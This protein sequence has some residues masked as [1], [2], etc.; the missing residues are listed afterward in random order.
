VAVPGLSL[1]VRPDAAQLCQPGLM[2]APPFGGTDRPGDILQRSGRWLAEQLGWRWVK[3]RCDAEV[4]AGRQ[5][6]RL[7]LQPS[8]WNRAGVA[9]WASTRVTVL[10]ED[11]KAW[12]Q[13]HPASTVL[14]AS[15]YPV[16]PHVYNTLL[17]NVDLDLAEV[18]CSGLPQRFP[19]PRVTAGVH[20]CGLTWADA[21]RPG[22]EPGRDPTYIPRPGISRCPTRWAA[23]GLTS[24]RP[25]CTP[26]PT[27]RMCA[28]AGR[29]RL[30]PCAG[31]D[32]L[33]RSGPGQR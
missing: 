12:R 7:G 27:L 20:V 11:L 2:A 9:T 1:S 6:R 30:W 29:V 5:A 21:C 10:D 25:G 13:A 24:P 33:M 8:K 15:Q 18:G 16:Q 26:L 31:F 19:A 32:P 22:S 14:P 17:I 3:G 4:R 23:S 28:G